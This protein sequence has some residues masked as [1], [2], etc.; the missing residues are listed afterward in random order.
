M[1]SETFDIDGHVVKRSVELSIIEV[2]IGSILHGL[3]I[4]MSGHFLSL[5]QGAFLSKSYNN[6]FSRSIAAKTTFEISFI[7]AVMKS[8]SPAGKKLG[9]M[10]SISSQGLLYSLGVFVGG[11]GTTGK[12]IGMVLLSLWAFIQPFISYF[13]MYGTEI[14]SALAYF[15]KKIGKVFDLEKLSL[16][17]VVVFLVG[18]KLIV[19][20]CVPFLLK[21][22]K[23]DSL[24]KKLNI[25]PKVKLK[26]KKHKNTIRGIFA[27]LSSPIFLM[28][29]IVM[30]LFFY[31][32]GED[33]A[34]IFWKLLRAISVFVLIS[35][36]ARSPKALSVLEKLSTR[37]HWVKRMMELSKKAS[38]ELNKNILN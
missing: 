19:A 30:A 33:S 37:S 36:L 21:F 5:N 13:L 9:P 17:Y 25:S 38:K 18:F 1:S 2:V 3:K 6:S 15:E 22:K 16:L 31:L 14:L 20:V 24:Y 28:S 27:D 23:I 11:V 8:L 34:I 35:Y 7:T 32:T 29:I 12:V 10:M 4:P 26:N